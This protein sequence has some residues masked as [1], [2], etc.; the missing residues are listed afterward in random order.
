MSYP[1]GLGCWGG[2]EV[3]PGRV[4]SLRSFL[5]LGWEKHCFGLSQL[6]V[7]C[8]EVKGGS[9][10]SPATFFP[11]AL[12]G[13]G[14]SLSSPHPCSHQCVPMPGWHSHPPACMSA[15]AV[16]SCQPEP[17]M[18][19]QRPHRHAW[20]GGYSDDL[21]QGSGSCS[22]VSRSSSTRVTK[23]GVSCQSHA[24]PS[25]SAHAWAPQ[26]YRGLFYTLLCTHSQG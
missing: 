19:S 16:P 1:E 24:N 18:L 11:P 4:W 9:T 26:A 23:S 12:A 22:P 13:W 8:Q 3:R 21:G 10:F 5:G 6:R 7:G 25:S 2:R 17:P 20:P 14:C 15:S